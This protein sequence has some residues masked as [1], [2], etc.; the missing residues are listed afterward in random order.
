MR[1]KTFFNCFALE[2]SV[3]KTKKLRN[4]LGPILGPD[5]N[6]QNPSLNFIQLNSY[7]TILKSMV[8]KSHN[9]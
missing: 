3:F 9:Q 8:K 4:V 2:L 1:P 5:F 6:I 7:C